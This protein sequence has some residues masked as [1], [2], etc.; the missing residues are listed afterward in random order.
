MTIPTHSEL[1][2][3]TPA[4]L[5]QLACARRSKGQQYK[6]PKDRLFEGSQM[7]PNGGCW[8]WEKT[9][10]GRGNIQYGQLAA[11]G[12]TWRANR[13][14]YHEFHGPIPEGLYVCH[15][16]D[17]SLCVNPDHLF[18][19][20]AKDNSQDRDAKGR[21][22]GAM[23]SGPANPSSKLTEE[24]VLKIRREKRSDA[25]VARELGCT[26]AAIRFARVGLTWKHVPMPQALSPSP[27]RGEEP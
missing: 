15:R 25:A 6:S 14:S 20:E 12:R 8:L 13:L 22:A 11:H 23:P 27:D 9:S 19:G 2:A 10:V 18:L 7:D 24:L 5:A 3:R 1:R 26:T 16:C 4:Q 17:V 21:N